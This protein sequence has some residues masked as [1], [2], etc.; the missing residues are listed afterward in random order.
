MFIAPDIHFRVFI[1]GEL[2]LDIAAQMVTADWLV[3]RIA[4][5][6]GLDHDRAAKVLDGLPP[7]ILPL[8]ESVDGVTELG[9][10][11]A[12]LMDCPGRLPFRPTLH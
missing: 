1:A 2:P 9:D 4:E 11:I 10:L 7:E 12:D 5:T 3:E 8:L 6:A